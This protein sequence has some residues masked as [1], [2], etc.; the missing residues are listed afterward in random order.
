MAKS[1]LQRFVIKI[2]NLAQKII[3][4]KTLDEYFIRKQILVETASCAF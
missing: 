3:A 2:G 1:S 4:F